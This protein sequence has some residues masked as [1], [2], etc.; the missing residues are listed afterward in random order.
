M[1][2]DF[3]C[4]NS[5]VTM[6]L[7]YGRRVMDEIM[8]NPAYGPSESDDEDVDTS[9][10]LC[11]LKRAGLGT[12]GALPL[13]QVL[14]PH[15]VRSQSLSISQEILDLWGKLHSIVA[16]WE[17]TMQKRWLKKNK[18]QRKKILLG[19]WPG[20]PT[21]H[22]PDFDAF[23]KKSM[24]TSGSFRRSDYL[25][26]H[27]N[28]EDLLKSRSL[29]LLLNSRGRHPPAAFA[30]A[31]RESFRFGV[32]S[33]AI[34][35]GFLNEHVMMFT[36]RHTPKTY[37]ELIAWKD[38][39]DAFE[40]L[41]SQRGFQPGDG[42]L[43]L[44]VQ[45]R[46]YKFCVDCCKNILHEKSVEELE[47][48]IVSVEPEPAS[49]SGNESG[50]ASLAA[51]AAEAPYRLPMNLNLDRLKSMLAAKLEDAEDH[52]WALREDPGYFA[53]QLADAKEHRQEQISDKAG[54]KLP[55]IED[56]LKTSILWQRVIGNSVANAYVNIE[57]WN[58]LLGQVVKLQALKEKHNKDIS[59][60]KDLPEEYAMAFYKLMHHLVQLSKAP[61]GVLKLGVFGSPPLR[62]FFMR[63]PY[64]PG[65]T[66]IRLCRK[67]NLPKNKVRDELLW[68]LETLFDEDR[69]I[70][71]NLGILMDELDR[72]VES[73]PTA[74]ELVSSWVADKISDLAVI[75]QCI[76]QIKLYQPWAALF[77]NRMVEN[78]DVLNEDYART[79]RPFA[80]ISKITISNSVTSLGTPSGSR[81]Y[82][83]VDKRRTRENTESMRTAE[84]NL[85]DFWRAMDAELISKGAV[86]SRTR[87][88]LDGRLLQRTPEWIEPSKGQKLEGVSA[89]SRPLAEQMLHLERST[90]STLD[91]GSSTAPKNKTK[92]RG[93]SERASADADAVPQQMEQ[94]KVDQQPEFQIDKRAHKVFKTIFF[95]PS[96]SSQPGEIAWGDFLHA[97]GSAGFSIEKLYGSAWQFTPTKLDV[98]RAI[99]FHEPHPSGKMPFAWARRIGRRLSKTYGW[100]GGMFV[101]EI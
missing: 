90:E 42:L 44:E 24:P 43:V 33:R 78:E 56:R 10:P 58:A 21:I 48:T 2:K 13:P 65:N 63:D 79:Q 36:D 54:R 20:M 92:T 82:Y 29:A 91:K 83:P 53:A 39:P 46:L 18:E 9:D 100:H 4:D 99:Q 26:P 28:Q 34:D 14:S 101:L 15:E 11:W 55:V 76:Q 5:W 16:N 37:G 94:L 1:L 89:L 97:M 49:V 19:A 50:V 87:S 93:T 80:A 22:R 57:I 47:G 32:V 88:L 62:T 77:E 30:T 84:K 61:I 7:A 25:W 86:T 71:L 81:F 41:V 66:I 60:G 3:R 8:N 72:L 75:S 17:A 40:W 6:D 95:T 51:A 98:E 96:T 70:L 74:K 27:I 52:L 73:E 45:K 31:D 68:L 64:D 35:V 12:P 38:N 59:P 85:D 67:G 23:K 69:L